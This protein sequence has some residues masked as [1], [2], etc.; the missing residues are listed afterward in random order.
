MARGKAWFDSLYAEHHRAVASYC[1]RRMAAVDA[2]DAVS[3]VFS[4]AW[5]RRDDVPGAESTLPW[6]YG[7]ARRVVSHHHR[8]TRRL[9]RLRGRVASIQEP[10]PLDP[11][12]LVVQRQEYRDVR[13]AVARL[14][15]PDREVLLLGAWEGLNHKQIGRILG[16]S[17]TAVDKRM[18]RAKQRLAREYLSM[19]ESS[20]DRPP[21]SAT[22]G[23]EL[24]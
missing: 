14:R 4:V 15:E 1:H 12:A 23:G 7:V 13:A 10:R 8:S 17:T 18:S 3:E 20:H 2:E 9:L 5:R 6:L 24:R 21:A 19:T 16:C 22:G 11:D